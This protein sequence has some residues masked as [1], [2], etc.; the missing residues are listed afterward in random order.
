MWYSANKGDD[1]SSDRIDSFWFANFW[2]AKVNQ[3]SINDFDSRGL[4][5]SFFFYFWFWFISICD[6]IWFY[7]FW[8][9]LILIRRESRFT[10][11]SGFSSESK[12]KGRW[13]VIHSFAN[14]WLIRFLQELKLISR[15]Q[16]NM[17]HN[18]QTDDF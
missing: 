5:K 18:I 4:S 1:Q 7:S 11:E 2:V 6:S 16:I 13:I 3:K 12:I 15:H 9:G 14:H 10:R 17:F 8:F